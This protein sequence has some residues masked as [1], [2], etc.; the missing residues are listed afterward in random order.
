VVVGSSPRRARSPKPSGLPKLPLLVPPAATPQGLPRASRAPLHPRPATDPTPDDVREDLLAVVHAARHCEIRW[1]PCSTRR[2]PPGPPLGVG[3]RAA[4]PVD[5]RIRPHPRDRRLPLSSS[6]QGG[7]TFFGGLMPPSTATGW[8]C[9]HDP[10]TARQP[11]S[12]RRPSPSSTGKSS[13]A[14]RGT[15]ETDVGEKSPG[16][17]EMTH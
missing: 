14:C 16:T 5:C 2:A 10:R 17:E 11:D 6:A 13:A 7:A 8:G 15:E 1:L 12:K 4:A 9:S 3:A